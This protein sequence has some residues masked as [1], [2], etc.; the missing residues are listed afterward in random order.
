VSLLAVVKGLLGGANQPEPKPAMA[1]ITIISSD[2]VTS[3]S[4]SRSAQ[5]QD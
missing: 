2:P 3:T 4:E 5:A 1:Q